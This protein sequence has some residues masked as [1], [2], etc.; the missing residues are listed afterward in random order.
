[1]RLAPLAAFTL[2]AALA[3]LRSVA[4]Q[5]PAPKLA[6]PVACEIGR[7]CEIQHYVDR[8]PGPGMLDYRCGHRT[9]PEHDGVDIR[10]LDM[11]AE[12]A[13]VDVLAAAPGRVI[14]VR[15]GVPDISVTAPGAPSVAGH[16]AGNRV[17]IALGGG[18]ILD[19]AHLANGSLKVKVGDTVSTGQPLA[20]VGL[21]GST[22]FPHLHFSV[23]HDDQVVD[24]F[25]PASPGGCAP[26]ASSLW[27]QAAAGEMPYKRGAVLNTG[28]SSVMVDGPTIEARA[29][30]PP[31]LIAPTLVAYA[32]L[33]GL[34]AGDV[35][36]IDLIGP[37]GKMLGSGTLAPLAT[38][39]DD[40]PAALGHKRPPQGWTRGAYTG[41][42]EV[43]RAGAVVLSRRWQV[44][45]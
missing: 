3:T 41:V 32:R 28:F 8:D 21:S 40:F 43:R 4:A 2:C 10:I 22:E 34:E 20:R 25:A 35:V 9:E 7:S 39:R 1:M 44:T 19:Y 45:L 33:I 30:P 42:V 23:R 29:A 17:G 37:D 12:R 26:D 16:M 13:G 36:R 14:A 15:N 24:P 31:T 27:T 11:G 5:P 6:F 38:N 18:W